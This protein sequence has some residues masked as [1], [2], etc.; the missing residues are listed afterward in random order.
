[1]AV[2]GAILTALVALVCHLIWGSSA[3][4]A[5]GMFG[6]LATVIQVAAVALLKPVRGAGIEK[7][8]IRWGAGMGLRVLGVI[9]IAVASGLDRAHFPPQASA[10]GFLGVLLPLLFFEVRLIR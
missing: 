8:I 10:T 9:A 4:L 6:A 7:F 1:M 3:A 2:G 5:A